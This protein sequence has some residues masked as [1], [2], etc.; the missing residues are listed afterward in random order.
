[1]VI[2]EVPIKTSTNA[3]RLAEDLSWRMHEASER[4]YI[5]MNTLVPMTNR[6]LLIQ[7]CADHPV[8]CNCFFRSLV[9]D[10]SPAGY[11]DC[12]LRQ[13]QHVERREG[14]PGDG[15]STRSVPAQWDGASTARF[16]GDHGA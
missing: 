6:L 1:M 16:P 3:T 2:A 5:I 4:L 13:C 7:L 11:L 14:I 15:C 12:G 8:S 9:T 10:I